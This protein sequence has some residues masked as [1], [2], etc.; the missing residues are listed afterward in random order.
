VASLLSS[1]DPLVVFRTS[2]AALA[3]EAATPEVYLSGTAR[4]TLNADCSIL[5]GYFAGFVYQE[6]GTRQQGFYP[7]V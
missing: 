7:Q 3:D 5:L 2:D 1:S 4:M 6:D